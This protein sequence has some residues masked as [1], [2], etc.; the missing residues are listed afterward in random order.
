MPDE[1]TG[2]LGDDQSRESSQTSRS[3]ESSDAAIDPRYD[4][5]FQRGFSGEVAIAPRGQSTLRRTAAVNPARPTP[6]IAA[7]P[8]VDEAGPPTAL[9]GSP[10]AVDAAADAARADAGSHPAA[11]LTSP[12]APTAPSTPRD[13]T[14]NPFVLALAALAAVLIIAG[15]VWA[16][17]GFSSIVKNGGTRNEVEFWAAQTMSFGA[18]LAIIAGLVLA[19]LLLAQFGR[20]WQGAQRD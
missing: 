13:L 18:P 7:P 2:E 10:A 5:A 19:G 16:F 4:P 11:S 14:R 6:V 12:S 17:Q 20:A 1:V 3:S 15:A 9:V 8:R